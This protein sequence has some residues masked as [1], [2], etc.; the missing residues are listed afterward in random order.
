MTLKNKHLLDIVEDENIIIKPKVNI[1]KVPIVL[2]STGEGQL[3]LFNITDCIIGKEPDPSTYHKQRNQ[4][5]WFTFHNQQN[6]IFP[7]SSS[8][9]LISLAHR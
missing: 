2:G 9:C 6:Q 8:Y 7:I 4:M 1:R 3:L 5:P